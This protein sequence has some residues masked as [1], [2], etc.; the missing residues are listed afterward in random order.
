[1]GS[2]LE[3][4]GRPADARLVVMVCD[5]LGS[6]NAAN[7]AIHEALRTGIAT[8]ASLQVPCPW[9]RGAAAN[10]QG[11]DVGVSLTVNAQFEVYR[12]GPITYAPSLLGGD[13]GF[14]QTPADVWE[15]ADVD[16]VRRE[17]RAQLERAVLW[18]FDPSHLSAH[19]NTL[20]ARPEFFDVILELAVE[21]RLPLSLPDPSVD[22]GFPARELAAAEGILVPDRVVVTS[23]EEES[24]PIVDA[25]IQSLV[26][27]VTEV[28][29]HPAVDSPELRAL[30]PN[31]ASQVSDAHLAIA[32]WTFRSALARSGAE[33]IGFRQ[34]RRAQRNGGGS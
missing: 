3:R 29:I 9:A 8:T 15:H 27:G 30:N 17:C 34:I 24:R 19:L 22:L 21:Y 4:L 32:D 5:G 23:L 11:D 13:G 33:L 18:G 20:C 12:W 26:P 16:E 7:N 14:P 1:M 10:H 28:H 2:L 6:S 31:W 25:A